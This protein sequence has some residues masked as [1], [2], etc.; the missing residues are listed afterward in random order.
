MNACV[1]AIALNSIILFCSKCAKNATAQ[2]FCDN[3]KD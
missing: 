2:K 3:S 1:N